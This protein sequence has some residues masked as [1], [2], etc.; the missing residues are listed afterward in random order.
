MLTKE[1]AEQIELGEF[2]VFGR[3]I[4]DAGTSPFEDGGHGVS[5]LCG[6][7]GQRKM[8]GRNSCDWQWLSVSNLVLPFISWS[9]T[10]IRTYT[11][12]PSRSLTQGAKERGTAPSIPEPPFLNEIGHVDAAVSL[13]WFSK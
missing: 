1:K 5:E 12:R 8:E 7:F 4:D 10:Y 6:L 3:L 9:S 13:S 2:A 11:T